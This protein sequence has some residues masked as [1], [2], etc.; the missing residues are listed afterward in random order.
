MSDFFRI[1]LSSGAD[2]IT[3]SQELQHITGY[4]N[5][6]RTRYRDILNYELRVDE[7]ITN[8]MMVKFLLQPLVENALYH[9]IKAKRGGGQITIVAQQREHRLYFSVSDN[10]KGMSQTQLESV[11]NSLHSDSPSIVSKDSASGGFGLRNV[12]M[13]IRLFYHQK[14]GLSITSGPGGTCVSFDIPCLDRKE[15]MHD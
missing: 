1:S 12:D 13:R 8:Y 11:L 6:Q 15:D 3:V 4:L 5:I 2:W 10:G 14:Q 7:Q 9:G